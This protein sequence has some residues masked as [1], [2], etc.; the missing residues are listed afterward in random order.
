MGLIIS[1]IIKN[2]IVKPSD[3]TMVHFYQQLGKVFY[4][5]AAVDNAVRKEEIDKLKQIIQ[6]EWLPIETTF[7]KF[8]SDSAYQI[9]IVFDWLVENKWDFE[10][11]LP[12]F[13][14]FREEHTH[15]FTPE[16]NT[17]ISKTA[18]AIATSF[19]GKN[20][21]EH[22]MTSQLNAILLEQY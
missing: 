19:S 10:Q 2:L 4:S 6:R 15:L 8:G 20:K 18:N 1:L 11:V 22:V 21:A 14:I 5:I 16:I 3:K 13:K 12:D 7:D 9:E 17:L